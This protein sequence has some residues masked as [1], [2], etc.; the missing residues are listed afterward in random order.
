MCSYTASLQCSA[1]IFRIDNVQRKKMY[2]PLTLV[3]TVFKRLYFDWNWIR[4]QNLQSVEWSKWLEKRFIIAGHLPPHSTWNC[5]WKQITE[6]AQFSVKGSKC[7]K[8]KSIR[9]FLSYVHVRHD[10]SRHNEHQPLALLLALY[11]ESALLAE[12]TQWRYQY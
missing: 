8:N 11:P 2:F 4:M 1:V 9:C 5:H 10:L 7:S 6:K 3:S 12:K